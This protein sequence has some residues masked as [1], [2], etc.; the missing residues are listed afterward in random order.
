MQYYLDI[1]KKNLGI[2]I[3]LGFIAAGG[4]IFAFNTLA[5]PSSWGAETTYN[6]T[7]AKKACDEASDDGGW[8][9]GIVGSTDSGGGTDITWCRIRDYTKSYST[10]GSNK[11]VVLFDGSNSNYWTYRTAASTTTITKTGDA[12]G[13]NIPTDT[14]KIYNTFDY[15]INS[16]VMVK[17]DNIFVDLTNTTIDSQATAANG[18]SIY[19]DS[20]KTHPVFNVSTTELQ[21]AA[22]GSP[23]LTGTPGLMTREELV[24]AFS[25]LSD[26]SGEYGIALHDSTVTTSGGYSSGVL[27]SG[28]GHAFLN[29]TTVSTTDALSPALRARDNGVIFAHDSTLSTAFLESPV[30][31]TAIDANS[32]I[33]VTDSTLTAEQSPVAHFRGHSSALIDHSTLYHKATKN[34]I[35]SDERDKAS[36]V[37]NGQSDTK[38]SYIDL[39][40]NDSAIEANNG[41]LLYF[42]DTSGEVKLTNTTITNPSGQL[43]RVQNG[44]VASYD[45]NVEFIA[46]NQTLTGAIEVDYGESDTDSTLNYKLTSA[47]YTGSINNANHS[48][49]GPTTVT[50]DASSTWVLTADS[51]V[52][53]LT[54][55]KSDHCNI[56]LNG[57]HLYVNDTALT[58]G[59][60][61]GA[62]TPPPD[63]G[64]EH[65]T[66]SVNAVVEGGH[67]SIVSYTES[68]VEGNTVTVNL[69]P[70]TDYEVASAIVNGTDMTSYVRNNV[71]SF[72]AG[73]NDIN[74]VI[75]F[76]R[77]QCTVKISTTHLGVYPSGA[78][79]VIRGGD[80]T[81]FVGDPDHGYYLSSILVNGA[82]QT[83]SLADGKLILT[84]INEDI[85]VTVIAKRIT[86]PLIEGSGQI[87]YVGKSTG[88]LRFRFDA[89]YSKFENG[90][91]VYID[92]ALLGEKHYTSAS[93]STIITID[94]ESVQDLAVGDHTLSVVFNDGGLGTTNFTV[95]SVTGVAVPDTGEL[96]A[97]NIAGAITS[98]TVFPLVIF[99]GLYLIRHYRNNRPVKTTPTET[100]L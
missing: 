56:S 96:T 98:F 63:P 44:P 22:P 9:G 24:S 14:S 17:K 45:S 100:K 41:Y 16:A 33:E 77:I 73:I 43:L 85:D 50:M 79:A 74:I 5:V 58:H 95:A 59:D 18:V 38:S 78:T 91:E 72:T 90:G 36:L 82:D 35:I 52:T 8:D 47:S 32:I 49:F 99:G 3:C 69:A 48:S 88:G 65:I 1:L 64:V 83:A 21:S 93:G 57:Y 60:C 51:Y 6:Y 40:I 4:S 61:G 87:H 2:I 39:T 97:I 89:D 13:S 34:S 86:Y 46:T 42:Y 7:I 53:S 31:T 27:A 76:Q 81:I 15:G 19:S 67:G 84:N 12:T 28:F 55:S 10:T 30:I 23:G 26:A 11:N 62:P 37:F 71:L 54:N 20:T 80:L 92:G 75:R 70:D 29:N 25:T 68:V 66:V 94:D